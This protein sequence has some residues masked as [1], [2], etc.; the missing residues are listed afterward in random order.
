MH[1]VLVCQ[2]VCCQ[3]VLWLTFAVAFRSLAASAFSFTYFFGAIA[4][5]AGQEFP[6]IMQGQDLAGS[7]CVAC[8][9]LLAMSAGKEACTSKD[10]PVDDPI[11]SEVN[12]T[13]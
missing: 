11:E 6:L 4:V 1:P 3:S 5:C 12:R 8:V 13:Q 7:S 9:R 2:P 10:D